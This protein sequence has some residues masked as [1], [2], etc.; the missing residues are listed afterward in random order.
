MN[1]PISLFIS[2]SSTTS[3]INKTGSWRFARPRYQD[4]TAP[5]SAACPAGVD[6]PKIERAV[7]EGRNERAWQTYME[8]NPF[9]SVCGRVCF[10]TCESACNRGRLDQPV[11]IHRLN[12]MIENIDNNILEYSRN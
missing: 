4:Q 7:A 8:E 11:N 3:R 6:I 5:C 12:E 10:H 2:R 1:K 9:P